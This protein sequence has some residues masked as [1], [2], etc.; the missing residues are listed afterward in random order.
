MTMTASM[1]AATAYSASESPAFPWVGTA[2]RVRPSDRA[3]ETVMAMPRSLNDSVGL[4]P[5][6]GVVLPLVLDLETAP[7]PI[8]QRMSIG[9]ARRTALAQ[10]DDV[11]AILGIVD[12]ERQQ[13]A[14]PPEIAS[15]RG[16]TSRQARVRP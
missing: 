5:K 13:A 12:V 3:I 6:P 4:A 2:S 9:Q 10:R 14:E 16:S 15:R 8:G 7:Q 1:P 11:A